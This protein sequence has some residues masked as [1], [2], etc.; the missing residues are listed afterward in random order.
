M[1]GKL[2]SD[3]PNLCERIFGDGGYASALPNFEHR[4]EQEK[5][6]YF[7]AQTLAAGGSLL[8]E[9]GTGVGKTLA[10]L[11][12]GIV[13]AKRGGKQLVVS[14]RTIALQRQIMEKDLPRARL[15]FSSVEDLSDCA[16]FEH[17]LLVGKSNYLCT[18]RLKRALAE[19]KE[20]FDS[21]ESKELER[22]AEWAAS[23]QTGLLEEL[24]PPPDPDVWSWVNA[25][26][27]SCNSRNCSDGSCF[28]QAARRNIAR[29]NVVV[30]NHNLLFSLIAAGADSESGILFPNDMLVLDEAH[31]IPEVASECFGIGLSQGGIMREL[32]RIYDPS[33]KRGLIT[34]GTLAEHWDKMTVSKAIS[35]CE[36]FFGRIGE[37]YVAMRDTVRLT[38]PNW[39]S[40]ELPNSLDSVADMLKS[41][42][43]NAPT[44]SLC[45]EIRDHRKRIVGIKNSLESC[46]YLGDEE[47]SVYWL[48]K[49]GSS[50]IAINAAPLDIAPILRKIL[51]SGTSPVILAS[52]TLASDSDGNM[53]DFASRIGAEHAEKCSVKSPFDYDKNMLVEIFSDA[54]EPD[55]N[56][57]RQDCE[58][59]AKKIS[60][61]SL[62]IDGG[63]LALF[64]S[65]RELKGT[66][67]IIR[68]SG[69]LGGRK[70][71]VQ[72]EMS[73]SEIIRRFEEAGNALLAGTDTFWTGIDIP[74]KTLSQVVITRLPFENPN[75]PLLAARMER[76]EALGGN[77]FQ[78][79]F[80]P[81]AIIKFRQGVGRLIRSKRDSGRIAILDS[82]IFSKSYGKKFIE[83]LPSK[84]FERRK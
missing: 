7:C 23:T 13:E 15:L 4:P 45:A 71:F 1:G 16:D 10:Y 28:Y 33:K 21:E 32:K 57:K 2:Q 42:E 8:F 69:L 30:L 59:L 50:N 37:N 6:A 63:T 26:S 31:T 12:P 80:L 20:L 66:V 47:S 18:H 67:D 40:D 65:Y 17:A 29:A 75:H 64:T 51:F 76:F 78:K 61:L 68:A 58:Y 70:I 48:E 27:S 11:I 82:R 54:P 46:I 44:D 77:S 5:M 81:S 34:R 25:D 36:D 41:F 53:E 22:I 72:G 38:S 74:G 79:I 39:E 3:L 55:K 52:A 19:K 62:Q 49:T 14:T 24:S 84:K 35:N 60:S 9:A 73:R 56:S 43:Q 83:A